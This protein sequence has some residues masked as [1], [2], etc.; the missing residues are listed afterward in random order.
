MQRNISVVWDCKDAVD[1]KEP[2]YQKT[3]L[4]EGRNACKCDA[5]VAVGQR[6]RDVWRTVGKM[7]GFVK[8]LSEIGE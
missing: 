6:N 2:V 5:G 1:F 7:A 8:Y 3:Q 4:G